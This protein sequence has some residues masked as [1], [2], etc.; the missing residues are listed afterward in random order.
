MVRRVF[1]T[2]E[3]LF[4]VIET[5]LVGSDITSTLLLLSVTP[6]TLTVRIGLVE[7]EISNLLVMHLIRV[8]E[9]DTTLQIEPSL[10]V[11]E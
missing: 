8:D 11:T 1:K 5:T 9:M 2:G 4:G 6:L 3:T 7:T 10:K